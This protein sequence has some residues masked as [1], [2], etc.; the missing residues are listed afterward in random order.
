MYKR[1]SDIL[2]QFKT[3]KLKLEY[4]KNL[5]NKDITDSLKRDRPQDYEDFANLFKHHPNKKKV[6]HMCDI[7][8]RKNPKFKTCNQ[9]LVVYNDGREDDTISYKAPFEKTRANYWI[10]TAMRNA[11]EYQ[12]RA[13]KRDNKHVC[14]HCGY[15]GEF[16]SVDHYKFS[17]LELRNNFLHIWTN[18]EKKEIPSN[19]LKDLGGRLIFDLADDNHF[20]FHEDWIEYHANHAKLRI[21]C[22][23]CNSRFSD[24][25]Y[26]K[27]FR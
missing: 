2:P 21:L 4:F 13:Y 3:K 5:L 7:K 27:S 18:I 25:G 12:I 23:S 1:M 26:R 17:F 6:L 14:V 22:R 20:T 16:L 10:D 15:T 9:L 19:F 8:I 24:Y 11:I